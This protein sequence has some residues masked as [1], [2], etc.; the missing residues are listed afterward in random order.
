MDNGRYIQ[1]LYENPIVNTFVTT[2]EHITMFPEQLT[3]EE[4]VVIGTFAFLSL[5]ALI[6]IWIK[7][8]KKEE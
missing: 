4:I 8:T 1:Y 5:Y 7:Y 2:Y 6:K 3:N